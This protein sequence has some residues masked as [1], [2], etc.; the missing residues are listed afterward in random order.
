MLPT[1]STDHVS[2]DHVYEPAEDSYLLL[3]T[4]SSKPEIAFLHARFGPHDLGKQG[5]AS[6]HKEDRQTLSLSPTPLVLEVGVGSGVVLAFVHA[7]AAILFGRRDILT[8]GTDVNEFACMAASETV[9]SASRQCH[10]NAHERPDASS[11]VSSTSSAFFQ[12]V[13]QADLTSPLRA[14]VVDV[15]IFN[16]P[17]VP[18]PEVPAA[19]YQRR[20]GRTEEHN[21]S[22]TVFERDSHLLALSYAGG[23]DGMEVTNKLL[24]R[25]PDI[26]SKPRGI[27]YILLCAQNLPEAVKTRVRERGCG[28][29]AETVGRSGIK[30]GWEKLQVIRIWR[31]IDAPPK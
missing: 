29:M 10:D 12:G 3:D 9:H 14:G 16:P 1:P 18:T 25:L 24:E 19:I 11:E 2:F 27:A 15:L 23:C 4:L 7:N 22:E 21:D 6:Q 28:W 26:L 30:G 20:S 17:Y 13:L 5:P 8:M 31:D